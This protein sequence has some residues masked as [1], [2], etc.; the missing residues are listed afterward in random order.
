MPNSNVSK[1]SASAA[2]SRR[3]TASSSMS[4]YN[5]E[6]VPL[7][8]GLPEYLQLPDQVKNVLTR[9]ISAAVEDVLDSMMHEGTEDVHWRGRMRKDGIVYY[10]DRESV[11]KEQTRFCCVDTTEASVE[12]VVN[13][14]VVSDTDMLLQRC[15]IMYDNIM[16]ARILNVLEHPSE[17]HPM[18]SSY[19]RYTAFKARTLQRNNRDMCVVVSTDVI[20]CS[21]GSTVGY[22][23]WDSLNLP[24]ISQLDVPQGFIRTRMFRS[25]YFVQN[26]GEPGAL[27]K[28]AYIVG[29]EAG[30]LAPRLTTRY[31]MPRFGE[32]LSRI[33]AHLRGRQLDP[34]TFVPQSQ[35]TDK[36]KAEFCQC[37]SKHFGAVKLLDTRRYNCVSCGD[38][39]CHACHH[40]EEIEVP[41]AR[42]TRVGICVGC[43]TDN[44]G[45]HSSRMS[46]WSSWGTSFSSDSTESS[47]R[48]LLM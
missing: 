6:G 14:F 21:D 33:I 8:A 28:V 26:S 20:Q 19:V 48:S 13:L 40:V 22:C 30:G 36:Q 31:Y 4:S 34:S 41:G 23:V 18:R 44:V 7:S 9:Q 27:T 38:A 42:N 25:G 35:W 5:A 15:R 11:T 43:K 24:D 46:R 32:V 37:C 1:R 29:I 10:E 17:E 39:I 16:D 45:K 3:L 2:L 12:E 47:T